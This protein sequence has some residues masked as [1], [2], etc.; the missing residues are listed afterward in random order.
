VTLS[1]FAA[2]LEAARAAGRDDAARL[3]A[4]H[5]GA[6]ESITAALETA[7]A[8]R[9]EEALEEAAITAHGMPSGTIDAEQ[10]RALK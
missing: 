5:E 7:R 8:A 9:R 2:A 1:A 4:T 10:I 6:R 3:F